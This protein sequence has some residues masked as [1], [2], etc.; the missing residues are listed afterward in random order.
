MVH[1]TDLVLLEVPKVRHVQ[2]VIVHL[3]FTLATAHTTAAETATTEVAARQQ[4]A[5]SE[6]GLKVLSLFVVILRHFTLSFTHK[7]SQCHT[8]F[9]LSSLERC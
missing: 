5:N 7:N 4:A 3:G 9:K 8:L 6:Q 2:V 1:F